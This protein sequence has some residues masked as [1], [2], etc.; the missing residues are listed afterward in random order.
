[1]SQIQEKRDELQE[2]WSSETGLNCEIFPCRFSSGKYHL[3]GYVEVP[4]EH[5]LFGLD[6][7]HEV[8]LML[9]WAVEK[10]MHELGKRGAID[11]FCM[12][13]RGMR[14]GDLFDVHGSI[15]Y[16][17]M[18]KDSTFWYG[19]D[20]GHCDDSPAVQDSAYVRGECESLARQI[21]A[22]TPAQ[23]EVKP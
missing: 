5:P 13:G 16:S 3:C 19:F 18:H 12:S 7:T 21:V 23:R 10:D 17:R 2:K 1:M 6:Y 8:P 15:T 4:R 20:C 14:C 22:L 11:V 9:S